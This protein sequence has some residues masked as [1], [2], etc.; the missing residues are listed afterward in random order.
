MIISNSVNASSPKATCAAPKVSSRCSSMLVSGIRDIGV[1]P[2]L[3]GGE[4]EG[5]VQG[6]ERSVDRRSVR[7]GTWLVPHKI[8]HQ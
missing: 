4:G 8:C 1:F 6:H 3:F 2:W 7:G 5:P